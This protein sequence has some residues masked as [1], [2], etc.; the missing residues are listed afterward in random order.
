MSKNQRQYHLYLRRLRSIRAGR[1]VSI[2]KPRRER[3]LISHSKIKYSFGDGYIDPREGGEN[4][5]CGAE[6]WHAVQPYGI[7]TFQTWTEHL[8][9]AKANRRQLLG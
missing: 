7:Y 2:R 9:E 5:I 3:T 6:L 4:C 8:S 1:E